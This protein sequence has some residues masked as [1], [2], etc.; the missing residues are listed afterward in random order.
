VSGSEHSGNKY[1]R[2]AKDLF[3]STNIVIDV[4]EVLNAFNVT[5]PA[6]QH[7]IKKLL[8]AGLRGKG[9]AEQDLREARDAIA[10]AIEIQVAKNGVTAN[11]QK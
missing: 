10:R 7:A 8:C 4:Y 6:T 3:S 11:E 2:I 9:N 5:C 1:H